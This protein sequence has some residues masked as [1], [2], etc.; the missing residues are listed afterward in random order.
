MEQLHALERSGAR[1]EISDSRGFLAHIELRSALMKEI[2]V[3]QVK[4]S[5]LAKIIKDVGEGKALDFSVDPSG[6][7]RFKPDFV[8]LRW[9]SLGV[10]SLG[11]LIT[12]DLPVT[13]GLPRCIRILSNYFS[14]RTLRRMFPIRV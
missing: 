4:D 7:L 11:R 6:V 8:S 14:G 10:G 12:L 5:S 9:T 2:K 13:Q 1:L 3:A